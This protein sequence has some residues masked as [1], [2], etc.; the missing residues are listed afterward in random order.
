MMSRTKYGTNHYHFVNLQGFL[1]QVDVALPEINTSR[2]ALLS[3]GQAS[4]AN[5]EARQTPA[6]VWTALESWVIPSSDV[7]TNWMN[8][9]SRGNLVVAGLEHCCCMGEDVGVD[10]ELRNPLKIELNV[11]KL[12]LSCT[13]QASAKSDSAIQEEEAQEQDGGALHQHGS[14]NPVQLREERI[15]LHPGER[16]VVHLRLRPLRAGVVHVTGVSWELNGI[17][18]GHKLFAAEQG[19]DCAERAMP[20]EPEKRSSS[21]I[22]LKVLPP[23]PRL[24]L[25]LEGFPQMARVGELVKCSMKLKNSG[26]MTLHALKAAIDSDWVYLSW[27][28]DQEALQRQGGV[29]F[30]GGATKLAVNEV[31][32]VD[33]YLRSVSFFI[34]PYFFDHCNEPCI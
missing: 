22:A 15:S 34:V 20:Q 27:K 3:S 31:I 28:D 12:R 13:F 29:V 25:L 5:V 24:E 4:Y 10:I 19:N 16:A 11:T 9:S 2:L 18:K 23:M 30:P 33:V 17:I 7:N 26:A 6:R 14:G 21:G 8:G 32:V 1:P